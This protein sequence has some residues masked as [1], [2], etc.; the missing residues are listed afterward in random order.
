MCVSSGLLFWEEMERLLN[1]VL[2][3]IH[4]KGNRSEC[5]VTEQGDRYTDWQSKRRSAL[6]LSL[7]GDKTGAFKHRKAVTF[8]LFFFPIITYRR[9]LKLKCSEGQMRTYKVTRGS[10]YD[11]DATMAVPEPY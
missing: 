1:W 10:H 2:I 3:P 9:C 11:A 6:A 7:C 8:K 5:T 4:K